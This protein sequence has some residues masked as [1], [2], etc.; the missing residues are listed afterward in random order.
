MSSTDKTK[1]EDP[2]ENYDS[3]IHTGLRSKN[4]TLWIKSIFSQVRKSNTGKNR[5]S[6]IKN[7][8]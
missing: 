3:E 7:D 5:E 6:E 4:H 2:I 8:K 1:K